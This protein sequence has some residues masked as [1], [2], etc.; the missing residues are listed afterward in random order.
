MILEFTRNNKI[1]AYNDAFD[2]TIHCESEEERQSFINTHEKGISCIEAL[3]N[4]KNQI[5]EEK[6]LAYADFDM[7]KASVLNTDPRCV[8][9]ELP[10]DE[11][12]C[13]L[14]RAL[15]IINSVIK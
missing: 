11:F 4:I 5:I 13:G 3:D 10:A 12:R 9:D 2:I 7:Y 14:D 8:K 6:E 1:K 15:D